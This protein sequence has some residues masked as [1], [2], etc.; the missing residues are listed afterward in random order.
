MRFRCCEKLSLKWSSGCFRTFLEEHQASVP[1]I[2]SVAVPTGVWLV[3]ATLSVEVPVGV[4]VDGLKEPVAPDG[5]P[6]TVK[7]T[8]ALKPPTEVT[9]TVSRAR[10]FRSS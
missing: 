2:V 8:P 7:D 6:V 4:T 10:K 5:K 9:V 1:V 3:V